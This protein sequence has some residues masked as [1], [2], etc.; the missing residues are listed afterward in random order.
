MATINAKAYKDGFII[1]EIR[2]C[3]YAVAQV[4]EKTMALPP[5]NTDMFEVEVSNEPFKKYGSL[6][7][8]TAEIS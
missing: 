8:L 6:S 3:P 4:W 7:E 2:S 5:Y 1:S